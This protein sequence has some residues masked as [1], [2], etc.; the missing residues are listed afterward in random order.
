[1]RTKLFYFQNFSFLIRNVVLVFFFMWSGVEIRIWKTLHDLI[2]KQ[3]IVPFSEIIN[4]FL[5]RKSVTY[6]VQW[7]HLVTLGK[8]LLIGLPHWNGVNRLWNDYV[9]YV[10][11][12]RIMHVM[13]KLN[14]KELLV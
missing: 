7:K 13:L 9:R 5:E 4:S 3:N 12:F 8:K 14:V 10:Y 2:Q 11:L 1:M 6:E